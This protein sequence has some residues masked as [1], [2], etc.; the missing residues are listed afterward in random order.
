MRPVQGDG[1]FPTTIPGSFTLFLFFLAA[2]IPCCVV[3]ITTSTALAR[4]QS[5]KNQQPAPNRAHTVVLG[6]RQYG[7]V[8]V[9]R[10]R[11]TDSNIVPYWMANPQSHELRPRLFQLPRLWVHWTPVTASALAVK[12]NRVCLLSLSLYFVFILTCGLLEQPE[13]AFIPPNEAHWNRLGAASSLK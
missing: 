11:W 7:L 2:Q 10:F 1:N 5:R 4:T 12:Y 3:D 6:R 8:S 13:T 9:L